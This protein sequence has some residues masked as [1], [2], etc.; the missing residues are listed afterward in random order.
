MDN[1]GTKIEQIEKRLSALELPVTEDVQEDAEAPVEDVVEEKT[2]ESKFDKILDRLEKALEKAERDLSPDRAGVNTELD[3]EE[4]F[5]K[6][7]PA[8]YKSIAENIA[9]TM[10]R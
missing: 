7:E 3:A 6:P 9:K 5:D 1:Y 10:V 2:S 4:E 8:S